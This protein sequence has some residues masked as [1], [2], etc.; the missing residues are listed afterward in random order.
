MKR[1]VLALLAVFS[2]AFGGT[3]AALASPPPPAQL[4][5]IEIGTLAIQVVDSDGGFNVIDA[6]MD[7]TATAA[8]FF[9][10]IGAT[11]NSAANNSEDSAKAAPLREAAA[12]LDLINLI[13][14]SIRTRLASRDAVALAQGADPQVIR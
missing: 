9:G 4:G 6:R 12:N 5:D 14:D 11:I 1:I 13:G 8:V 7:E 2:L 10:M 3:S